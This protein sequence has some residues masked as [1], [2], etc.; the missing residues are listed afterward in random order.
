VG[1][2]G[3]DRLGVSGANRTELEAVADALI[4]Y[5]LAGRRTDDAPLAEAL[6]V[7]AEWEELHEQ[8][9]QRIAGRGLLPG[10]RAPRVPAGDEQA[11]MQRYLEAWRRWLDRQAQD[12]G[13]SGGR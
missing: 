4:G 6:A 8:A 9:L 5:Y 11:V 3:Q 10:R 12:G 7:W 13:R 2:A 1:W